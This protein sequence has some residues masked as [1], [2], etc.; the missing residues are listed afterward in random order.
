MWADLAAEALGEFQALYVHIKG[1]DVPAHDGRAEDKRD[2]ISAIDRAFFGT[3][4]PRLGADTIVAVTAD[5]A[6]SCV[7]KAHTADP[8]PFLVSGGPV[9][10][11]GNTSFGETSCA[12]GSLGKMLGPQILPRLSALVL[13]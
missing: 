8:V 7:R 2:V 13:G 3:A 5:H 9:S 11:D 4:L 1:P 6:T 12:E 10:A